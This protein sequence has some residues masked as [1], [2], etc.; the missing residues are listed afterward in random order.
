MKITGK[1]DF[2]KKTAKILAAL[3]TALSL[4]IVPTLNTAALEKG[5][6]YESKF[7]FAHVID[8]VFDGVLDAAIGGAMKALFSGDTLGFVSESRRFP[9]VDEYFAQEHEYFY[10]GTNGAQTGDGWKLGYAQASVIPLSWRENAA[11]KQD[12]KGMNL[13]KTY[14]FGGYFTST[15]D[16]IYDDETLNLAVLSAGTDKNGNGIDDIFV[17]AS[18]DNIGMS[19]GNIRKIRQA[20]SEKLVTAGIAADDILAIEFNCTHAHSVVE[21]L[22]MSLDSV[23]LTALKNHFLFTKDTAVKKDLF[24]SICE[25]AA[26]CAYKAYTGMKDG[27]LYYFETQNLDD[28]MKEN[29][30]GAEAD[31]TYAVA[32]D[33][34]EYGADCQK[35][36]ACW[37]FKADDGEK[38][39]LANIGMHPTFAGRNSKR[40]CADYPYYFNLAMQSMG[41]N[42][43]F[44]QGSQ[45]AIG[46]NCQITPEGAAWAEENA[47][48][49]EDWVERY[50]QKYADDKFSEEA[51]YARI[52]AFGYS[53]AQAVDEA[54]SEDNPLDPVIDI[55]MGEA[56]IPFDYSVMYVAGNSGVFGYN[57]VRCDSETGYGLVTE[58]GYIQLGNEIV[59]LTLPGEVSPAITFG[60]SDSYTGNDTW[61]GDG[62][63]SG[64]EWKYDTLEDMAKAALGS[65]KKIIAMG[66]ANDEVGYIMPD[67]DTADNFLT[68]TILADYGYQ[69]GRA[70]NEELMMA[71]KNSGSALAQAFEDFF[72]D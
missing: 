24:N 58:I 71:S 11:G 69:F 12:D 66:L 27:Q 41:Y 31:K 26:N 35:F 54:V 23:F 40:V 70:D 8:K 61:T 39:V 14:W 44:I 36:F 33:K 9:T 48:T 49:K 72:A 7:K 53:I 57:T 37:Y 3:I 52:R 2:M 16:K 42:A 51:D 64:E 18:L 17:I 63:W 67:T 34:L 25:Q 38:T 43:I 29:V 55:K 46:T 28:F 6:D 45:A 4:V 47:L 68:K 15:V 19:N 65:D 1:E 32:R 21:A 10:E 56:V 5:S 13:N 59:M 60:K 20:I 62:S 22:G 30:E 50:G